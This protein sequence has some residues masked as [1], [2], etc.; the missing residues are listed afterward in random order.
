[1]RL[2]RMGL[3]GMG[4]VLFPRVPMWRIEDRTAR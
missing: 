1:M 3:D 4:V 2:F